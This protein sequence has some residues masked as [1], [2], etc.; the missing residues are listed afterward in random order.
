MGSSPLPTVHSMMASESSN[1]QVSGSPP[2]G[3]QGGSALSF[4]EAGAS[5][6]L[7]SPPSLALCSNISESQELLL[8]EMPT[9]GIPELSFPLQDSQRPICGAE[10]MPG[11]VGKGASHS[12][13]LSTPLDTPT[14]S[15]MLAYTHILR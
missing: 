11:D 5:F 13:A 10:G 2:G 8:E 9:P 12:F 6:K 14:A 15:T 3:P 4:E 7:S 1:L